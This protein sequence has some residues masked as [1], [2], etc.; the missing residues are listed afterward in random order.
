MKEAQLR[1]FVCSAYDKD[2]AEAVTKINEYVKQQ[3]SISRQIASLTSHVDE[4]GHITLLVWT[5]KPQPQM[6]PQ[7]IGGQLH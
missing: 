5:H 1:I 2:L 6:I 4:A 3:E 7:M